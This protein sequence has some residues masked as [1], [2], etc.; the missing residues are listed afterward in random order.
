MSYGRMVKEERRLQAE[1]GALLK[2]AEAVDEAE[3]CALR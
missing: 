2:R 3:G 1:I